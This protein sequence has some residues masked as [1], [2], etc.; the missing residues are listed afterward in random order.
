VLSVNRV[1][2]LSR[3][4]TDISC[5]GE[6]DN[7]GKRMANWYLERITLKDGHVWIQGRKVQ[8]QTICMPRVR[9]SM[10]DVNSMLQFNSMCKMRCQNAAAQ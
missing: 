3:D 6:V 7:K 2:V 8:Q 5:G 4:T 9:G 1:A 10:N